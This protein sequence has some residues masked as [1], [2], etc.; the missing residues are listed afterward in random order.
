MHEFTITSDTSSHSTKAM[1]VASRQSR[2]G[3]FSQRPRRGV[4]RCGSIEET[5]GHVS[6]IVFYQSGIDGSVHERVVGSSTGLVEE[7]KG[8]SKALSLDTESSDRWPSLSVLH[9]N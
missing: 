7:K 1:T 8:L 2:A 9:D 4:G 5:P 6:L 3:R